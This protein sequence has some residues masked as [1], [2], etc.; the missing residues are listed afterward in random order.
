MSYSY[1]N[2]R[3]RI[4]TEEGQRMFLRIRDKTAGLLKMAGAARMQEM[5][6]GNSGAVWDMIA[7]VDR[8]VELGEIREITHGG[9]A[10]QY[11][12]FVRAEE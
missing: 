5:I 12:V 1:A 6:A 9:V 2:E 11:R 4:F 7:C 8:M 10:G 3:A